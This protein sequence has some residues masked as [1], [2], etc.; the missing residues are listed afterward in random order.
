[1]AQ[2]LYENAA[3]AAK[4]DVDSVLKSLCMP[5]QPDRCAFGAGQP[6]GQ[7][8]NKVGVLGQVRARCC[9]HGLAKSAT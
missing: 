8:K 1:M 4:D 6:Q 5:T 3:E 2:T 7:C 9:G